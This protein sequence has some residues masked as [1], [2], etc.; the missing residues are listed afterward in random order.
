M[1]GKSKPLMKMAKSVIKHV[2]KDDKEFR[3]QIKDDS[4]LKSQLKKSLIKRA[5]GA[6]RKEP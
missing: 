6:K 1:A 5:A 3:G 2:N 4:K